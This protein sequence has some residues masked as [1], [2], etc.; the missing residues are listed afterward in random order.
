MGFKHRDPDLTKQRLIDAAVRLVLRQGFAATSVEAIC[1]GA[2]LTKGSFFHHFENKESI[3]L[4]VIRWW[5]AMGAAEYA[6]AWTDGK[7]TALQQLHAM[8]DIMEGFTLRPDQPCVCAIGM[9]AQEMATTHPVIR[10]SCAQELEVWTSHVERLLDIAK[11]Q[12]RVESS[13]DSSEVAWF[14]N[15]LWQG[16][17][18]IGKTRE[19]QPMIRR[20]L[21]LARRFID[22]L[23]RG[24]KRINR[25]K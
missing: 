11:G 21:Q 24:K 4:E 13:F 19:D 14:L 5:S 2:G 8:L 18:L 12:E 16:S 10:K 3:G 22:G 20:N 7:G 6:R 17:M 1:T 15:S 9:M 23:F 25:S